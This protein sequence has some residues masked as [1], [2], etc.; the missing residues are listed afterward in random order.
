MS[1]PF[2]LDE[3]KILIYQYLLRILSIHFDQENEVGVSLT[4]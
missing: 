2:S 1:H 3:N 4:T